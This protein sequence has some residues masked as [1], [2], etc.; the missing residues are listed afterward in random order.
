MLLQPT[1]I[2]YSIVCQPCSRMIE[3][4]LKFNPVLV[5][6]VPAVHHHWRLIK[7][8]QLQQPQATEFWLEP[9]GLHVKCHKVGAVERVQV[10]DP[11]KNFH[12]W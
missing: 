4:L 12:A 6:E 8:R 7:S 5:T 3:K 11:L 9:S 10:L 2:K 1:K